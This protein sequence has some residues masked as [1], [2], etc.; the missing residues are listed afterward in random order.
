MAF[1]FKLVGN[2]LWQGLIVLLMVSALSFALLATAGGDA[3]TAL[4]QNPQVSEETLNRLRQ[5]YGFDQP[6][7]VR[8]ARWLAGAARGQLGDSI[9]YQR[10][11]A[12]VIWPRWWRTFSVAALA[13]GLAGPLALWLGLT[14]AQHANR[15]PHRWLDRGCD[16]VVLLGA[17]TPRLL[18]AL[19][20]LAWMTQ[21]TPHSATSSSRTYAVWLSALVLSVPLFA[22]LLAQTRECLAAMQTQDHVRVARAKGLPERSVWFRHVL[23][24]ALNPLISVFGFSLGGVLSGS[25]VVEQ[26]LD[27]PGIGQLSVIAVQ[28]RDVPLMLGVVLVAATAV[29]L[30]NLLADLLLR[31]NDPRLRDE[32]VR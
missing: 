9:Y 18:L 23:R 27:S 12:E 3:L 31:W 10:P 20:A 29:L 2:R 5:V 14:A 22:L 24:P 1:P 16:A 17:S 13:F 15:W 25:A 21:A 19:A 28:S 6:L 30:S 32:E 11:V 26:V 7:V 8:Y 4:Q